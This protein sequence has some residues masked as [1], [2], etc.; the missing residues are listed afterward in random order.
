MFHIKDFEELF[1]VF[2]GDSVADLIYDELHSVCTCL[3]HNQRCSQL[4]G[5]IALNYVVLKHVE[6]VHNLYQI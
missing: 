3:Q 5:N 2:T 4:R 6:T 1:H